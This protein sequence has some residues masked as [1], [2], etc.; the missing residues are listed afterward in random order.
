[1]SEASSDL[2]ARVAETLEAVRAKTDAPCDVAVVLGSG[3]GPLAD[4]IEVSC[5]IPFAE[6]PHF[7]PPRVEGHD[8][9]LIF[10]KLEGKDVVALKGRFHLYE[11]YPP[12]VVTYPIRLFK[13]LGV[14]TL[15]LTN[16]AGGL[17]RQYQTGDLMVIEDHINFTFHD[18]LLGANDDSLGPR[19]LD[20]SLP[21]TPRLQALAQEV[22]LELGIRTQ[23]GV[24]V[25]I[26]GPTYD[27]PAE[28]RMMVRAGADA[29]GMSVVPEVIVATHA[30]IEEVVGVS[31]IT[32]MATGEDAEPISHD[33]VLAAAAAAEKDFCRLIQGLV[34]R[35]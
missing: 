1:M 10:G 9:K 12:E 14:K 32:D 35:L 17:N 23:K 27:T 4:R 15:V 5:E 18:P 29:I 31:C 2:S 22:G 24:L 21:Y 19:F 30:G 20:M 28:L 11:G 6:I 25:T 7:P 34:A 13:A 26:L 8:G 33:Q 16:A 3:L